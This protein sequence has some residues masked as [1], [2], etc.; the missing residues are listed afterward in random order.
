MIYVYVIDCYLKQADFYCKSIKQ[1]NI[2]LLNY[3]LRISGTSESTSAPL[4][5]RYSS[6][7]TSV[8]RYSLSTRSNAP[9]P[10]RV[11]A[12]ISYTSSERFRAPT[13]A[14]ATKSAPTS[15]REDA[16][17]SQPPEPQTNGCKVTPSK[18]DEEETKDDVSSISDDDSVRDSDEEESDDEKEVVVLTMVTR[19]TSPTI[20]GPTPA[21]TAFTRTKR[22][23][24]APKVFQKEVRRS[25]IK[26]VQ[27][28]EQEQQVERGAF[29][30]SHRYSSRYSSSS[31]R[32]SG[33]PWVSSYLDKYSSSTGSASSYTPR[34]SYG[35]THRVT[36]SYGY[37]RPSESS[38]SSKDNT[39][40]ST[41]SISHDNDHHNR[42][43]STSTSS[44]STSKGTAS[45][46]RPTDRSSPRID[47]SQKK[48]RATPPRSGTT[49][50]DRK[51]DVSREESVPRVVEGQDH[52]QGS[53][54]R[55]SLSHTSESSNTSSS[56]SSQ[57][58][59]RPGSVSR[60][61]SLKSRQM[62][63]PS[64]T[65]SLPAGCSG[66]SNS[67]SSSSR[68]NKQ[69]ASTSS[70]AAAAAPM[71]KIKSAA[72]TSTAASTGSGGSS[73][74]SGKCASTTAGTS[75]GSRQA[76]SPDGARD[77]KP[78]VP[79]AEMVGTK[80]ATMAAGTGSKYVNKDF[81]K[82]ALNMENGDPSRSQ[83]VE[84]KQKKCQRSM[85]VSSQDSQS[86]ANSDSVLA[87]QQVASSTS[88][89]SLK[90]NKSNSKSKTPT[91]GSAKL[92]SMGKDSKRSASKSPSLCNNNGRISRT[93]SVSTSDCTSDGSS[94]E[95][96]NSDEEEN[97]QQTRPS[98]RRRRQTSDSQFQD[99]KGKMSLGSSRTSV[100]AS[101]ADELSVNTDKPPRPPS[102]PRS[103]SDKSG[104]TDE[105]KSFLMRA[106]APVT[107]LFKSK[108]QENGVDIRNGGWADADS[109][110][111]NKSRNSAPKSVTQSLSKSLSFTN[112]EKSSLGDKQNVKLRHQSSGEKPW[113]LDPNSENVPEGVEINHSA[114][115]DDV[116]Q[117]TTISSQ[118][119][120]DG[121]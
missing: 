49:T 47:T 40:R 99:G 52:D 78:P 13:V 59:S 26:K 50:E 18:I 9:V 106:L 109:D 85:S 119:P 92:K 71:T 14:S 7:P 86:E 33:V 48:T 2:L 104:K 35:S 34:S 44:S 37:S 25:E 94:S 51:S 29:E 89:A 27:R 103:K 77:R 53:S 116:S 30:D 110:S 64:E 10:E 43:N 76:S 87:H 111:G 108:Q 16:P 70:A 79:K 20:P 6:G 32:A 61:G 31:G 83:I 12:S 117:D 62:T 4:S 98:S 36:G 46:S 41:S 42:C 91:S 95:S 3:F 115:N 58:S 23:E 11:T 105:A 88:S 114:A 82:S 67:S 39:S 24:P 84:R 120:D 65:V 55:E 97:Q 21:F 93:M 74:S 17:K 38:Y 101:S 60:S 112:S 121:N 113:W 72:T 118:L 54:R 28:C 75:V 90:S 80:S 69:P 57:N 81:R 102:S 1:L 56:S 66:V 68:S 45:S 22:I 63:P 73:S 107:N 8:G 19:G 96:S 5:S 100:L 15:L